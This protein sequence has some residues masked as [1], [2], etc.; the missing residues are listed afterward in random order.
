VSRI[1]SSDQ[2]GGHPAAITYGPSL[3]T[4]P[5]TNIREVSFAAV[6]LAMLLTS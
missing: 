4:S 5:G 1:E 2:L 3:L 6:S